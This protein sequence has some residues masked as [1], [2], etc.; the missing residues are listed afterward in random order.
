M[1]PEEITYYRERAAIERHRAET[2]DDTRAAAI[3]AE[4]ADLYNQLVDLEREHVP[5]LRL[6]ETLRPATA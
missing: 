4:L 6:V 1:S 3:H 5:N 2:S